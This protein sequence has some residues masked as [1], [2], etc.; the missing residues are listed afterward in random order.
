MFQ[1][2]LEISLPLVIKEGGRQDVI[3]VVSVIGN[4]NPSAGKTFFIADK[5]ELRICTSTFIKSVLF[6]DLVNRQQGNFM[7]PVAEQVSEIFNWQ[8]AP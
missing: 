4:K 6:P 5:L 8:N 3:E 7:G 1:V 2:I